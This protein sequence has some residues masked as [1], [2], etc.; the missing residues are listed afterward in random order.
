MKLERTHKYDDIIHLP[1]PVSSRHGRMSN[2]DRA[3]QFSPFSALTGFDG[4]ISETGR[5]TQER[6]ELDEEEKARVDEVLQQVQQRIAQQ[7]VLQ[8]TWFDYDERKA[9]GTY[10]TITG[11]VKKSDTYTR[12]IL[13]TDGSRVPIG[14]IFAASIP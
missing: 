13:F 10:L 2:Y 1:H 12:H 11:N 14:E 4:M 5:L 6:I 9:G 7:P 8:V 3:A